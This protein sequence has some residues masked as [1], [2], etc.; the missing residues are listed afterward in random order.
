M[1]IAEIKT[2][3]DIWGICVKVQKNT[4]FTRKIKQK[5]KP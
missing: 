5:K 2:A 3:M 1:K 4:T